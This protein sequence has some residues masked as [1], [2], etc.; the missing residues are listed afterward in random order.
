MIVSG[1][2][3]VHPRDFLIAATWFVLIC[4]KC[5]HCSPAGLTEKGMT[6]SEARVIA[7]RFVV[8]YIRPNRQWDQ[9]TIQSYLPT[10]TT[11][12]SYLPTDKKF[13]DGAQF[14]GAPTVTN[15][16][17]FFRRE[18]PWVRSAKNHDPG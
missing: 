1:L 17:E 4:R 10:Q 11:I 3:T 12:Q 15:L 8:D 6:R 2:P 9:T 13:R 16:S 14:V 5:S 7:R 18:G